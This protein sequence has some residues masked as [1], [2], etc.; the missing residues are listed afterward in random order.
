MANSEYIGLI[1]CPHC[2][3]DQA[4]VHQQ[5][6]GSKKGRRYY[7]CYSEVNGYAMRCGTVQIL[8]P[9]GQDFIN[10]NMRP[11]G[12]S[13]A[14]PAP[15]GD[16]AP[17]PAGDPPP[18]EQPPEPVPPKGEGKPRSVLESFLFGGDDDD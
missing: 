17:A 7:R 3:N 11:I 18:K 2:G 4:T 1:T 13:P 15:I 10:A 6:T 14:E 9:T 12:E 16:P 8:G 5:R